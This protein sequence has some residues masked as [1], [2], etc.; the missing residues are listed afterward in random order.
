MDCDTQC[1]LC[2]ENVEDDVHTFFTCVFAQSSWQVA[3]LS[4]VIVS[5]L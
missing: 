1:S 5:S 3:R 4:S 2:E